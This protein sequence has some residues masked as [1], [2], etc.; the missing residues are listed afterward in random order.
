M[1]NLKKIRHYTMPPLVYPRNDV[2][3]TS[4]EIP[5]WWH[6]TSQ[7]WVVLLIGPAAWGKFASTNH[8]LYPD[9]RSEASSAFNFCALFSGVIS[10]GNQGWRPE[11]ST[12]FQASSWCLR[13]VNGGLG[14][15]SA[16]KIAKVDFVIRYTAIL[17]AKT[18]SDFK[19]LRLQ[20]SSH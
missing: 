19:A 16:P 15:G 2:W 8:K 5:F 3:E 12:V 17:I 1:V 6:V 4:P 13:T 9:L 11:M 7:I 20:Y 14:E 10:L 18:S